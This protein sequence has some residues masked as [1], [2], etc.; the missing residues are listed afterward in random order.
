M[1][2]AIHW[3]AKR[4]DDTRVAWILAALAAAVFIEAAGAE[5]GQLKWS[6]FDWGQLLAF[7]F[8]TAAVVVG[9]ETMKE[10]MYKLF[11]A[12]TVV[13]MTLFVVDVFV[14]NG[15]RFPGLRLGWLWLVL[16]VFTVWMWFMIDMDRDP[17][18]T[19]PGRSLYFYP[20]ARRLA[21]TVLAGAII[22]GVGLL[23]IFHSWKGLGVVAFIE[24]LSAVV[25]AELYRASPRERVGQSVVT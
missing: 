1:T 20:A 14:E 5:L 18:V 12:V 2:E 16:A 24:I 15:S 8:V 4:L 6:Y 13:A 11:K 19:P 22:F 23:A 9:A 21:V 25:L 7:G 17:Q 10:E 3:A